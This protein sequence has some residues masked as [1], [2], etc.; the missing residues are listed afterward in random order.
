[1]MIRAIIF[2]DDVAKLIEKNFGSLNNKINLSKIVNNVFREYYKI[3]G[4]DICGEKKKQ[5]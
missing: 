1:M 4:D 2:D 3:M 5:N